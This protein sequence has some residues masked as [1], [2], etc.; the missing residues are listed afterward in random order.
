[1][2]DIKL[3]VI[4]DRSSLYEKLYLLLIKIVQLQLVLVIK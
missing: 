2:Y 3:S 1:M 4:Y